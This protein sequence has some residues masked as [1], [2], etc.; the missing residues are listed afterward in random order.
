MFGIFDTICRWQ[1]I[2]VGIRHLV[3][4]VYTY[5]WSD[6]LAD[7]SRAVPQDEH[8]ILKLS[9]YR[10]NVIRTIIFIILPMLGCRHYFNYN[11][12]VDLKI[13]PTTSWPLGNWLIE[14]IVYYC[15]IINTSP[16]DL[17]ANHL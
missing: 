2:I 12:P 9:F 4:L 14:Y 15:T 17:Q 5:L 3:Y 6:D 16:V 1:I 8:L 13:L 11:V 7:F 10:H